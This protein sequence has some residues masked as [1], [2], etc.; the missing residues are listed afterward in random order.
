[1]PCK[2]GGTCTSGPTPVFR[3]GGLLYLRKILEKYRRGWVF[4]LGDL[5]RESRGIY[6]LGNP[7]FGKLP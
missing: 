4:R 5:T 6:H 7:G 1:M 2:L 3:L